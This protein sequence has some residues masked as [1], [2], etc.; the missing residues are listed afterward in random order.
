[1]SRPSDDDNDDYEEYVPAKRRKA[2]AA[3]NAA[4]VASRRGAVGLAAAAD[5]GGR[6]SRWCV[7]NRGEAEKQRGQASA[8]AAAPTTGTA[9][10]RKTLL[11]EA[12]E[13]KAR[14]EVQEQTDAQRMAEAEAHLLAEVEKKTALKSVAE[15]A[16][17]VLYTEPMKSSWRAPRFLLD[18]PASHHDA[19]REQHHVLVEGEDVPPCCVSF[20]EMKL[21]KPIMRELKRRGIKRPTPIQMQGLPAVLA[22]RDLIGISF[23][24]S[25]KTM[26]FAFPPPTRPPASAKRTPSS[27]Q[28][29]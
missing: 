14:F 7:P 12:A 4:A 19:V 18:A 5:A 20:A 1:M 28:S 23:T 22:G 24:G 8:T 15:L 25:G 21:P 6:S 26:V 3:R 2:D 13:L 9:G 16:S 29:P 17:G 11:D 27:C 10:G